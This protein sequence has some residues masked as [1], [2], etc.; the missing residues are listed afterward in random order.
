M[1]YIMAASIWPNRNK[2]IRRITCPFPTFSALKKGR[3]S[4]N[5][6]TGREISAS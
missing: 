6:L 3:G 4:N 2:H 1:N 5:V